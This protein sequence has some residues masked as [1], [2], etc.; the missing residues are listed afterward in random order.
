MIRIVMTALVLVG[1]VPF[2]ARTQEK[3]GAVKLEVVKYE[4]LKEAI[5]KNR[6][7][8]VYVDFW[9]LNCPPCLTG[10]PHLVDLHSKHQDKGLK[11]VT[12]NINV[13]MRPAEEYFEGS[14]KFLRSKNAVFHNLLLDEGEEIWAGKL[15]ADFPSVYVFDRQGRWTQFDD[16][17]GKKKEIDQLVEKLLEETVKK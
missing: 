10:F 5:L 12:V 4:G 6:G 7:H 8:V 1:C 2:V 17:V 11:V 3:A 9:H 13:L 14:L 16:P 15:R